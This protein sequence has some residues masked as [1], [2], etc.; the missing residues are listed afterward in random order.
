MLPDTS[1]GRRVGEGGAEAG[2]RDIDDAGPD[3]A[4]DASR[5]AEA[6][7]TSPR[8]PLDDS[9]G[10]GAEQPEAGGDGFDGRPCNLAMRF[11]LDAPIAGLEALDDVRRFALSA[12][13]RT[14]VLIRADLSVWATHRP[15]A[16]A[17]F[18]T[19]SSQSFAI[20]PERGL[21]LSTDGSLLISYRP[22]VGWMESWR[23]P[24]GD[25]TDLPGGAFDGL[26]AAM[27]ASGARA[28]DFVVSSGGAIYRQVGEVATTWASTVRMAD[29]WDVG[30]PMPLTAPGVPPHAVRPTWLSADGES[31]VAEEESGGRAYFVARPPSTLSFSAVLALG[32]RPNAHL[33]VACE[34]IVFL[35][36]GRVRTASRDGG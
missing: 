6:D 33:G 14:M 28:S 18:A 26:E 7:T 32:V 2:D 16:S 10:S 20:D 15:D 21:T 31:F 34:R 27:T 23:D 29:G 17:P 1:S 9:G 5:D 3:D 11:G 24:S 19:P 4:A 35:A 22:G 12:D 36:A 8:V 25:F 30:T 13:Q